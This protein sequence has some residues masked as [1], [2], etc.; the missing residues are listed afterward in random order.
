MLGLTYRDLTHRKDRRNPNRR[1]GY[2]EVQS[3]LRG[4][5]LPIPGE[6]PEALSGTVPY[7]LSFLPYS[8]NGQKYVREQDLL[9]EMLRCPD[10]GLRELGRGILAHHFGLFDENKA[11]KC[12]VTGVFR[13]FMI[14]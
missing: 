10:Q 3:W 8:F 11:G 6:T 9:R 12:P 2:E 13:L 1:W 5:R 4:V 7:Q 14:C